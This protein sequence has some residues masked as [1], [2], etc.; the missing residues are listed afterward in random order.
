LRGE[1][2]LW[3]EGNRT[4]AIND[5]IMKNRRAMA[6]AKAIFEFHQAHIKKAEKI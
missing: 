2:G 5:E 4:F 6:S 3:A 1:T